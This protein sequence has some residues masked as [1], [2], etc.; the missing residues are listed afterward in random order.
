MPP[1]SRKTDLGSNHGPWVPSPA[2]EGSGDVLIDGLPVLRVGDA[3][4]PHVKPGS[5]PHPRKVAAGSPSI[6]V[7]GR[8]V[9]R[10]GDAIDCGGKMQQGSGT[11]SCDDG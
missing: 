4:A 2:I 9:A 10:V 8:P 3:L 11:V 1:I 6:F 7:N 5:P